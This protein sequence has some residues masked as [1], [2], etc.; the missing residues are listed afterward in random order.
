VP[1]VKRPNPYIP[2]EHRMPQELFLRM[3]KLLT[4]SGADK[5]PFGERQR[6]INRLI[7][8]WCDAQENRKTE[9]FVEVFED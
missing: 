1:R 3:S 9:E 7:R 4:P 2:F 6:L 8:D 5:V